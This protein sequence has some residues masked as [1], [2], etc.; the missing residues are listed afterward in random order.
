MQV[1]VW[2]STLA[3]RDSIADEV[4]GIKSV[5]DSEN[6]KEATKNSSLLYKSGGLSLKSLEWLLGRVYIGRA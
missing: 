3:S 1:W 5:H 2:C 6:W 4:S